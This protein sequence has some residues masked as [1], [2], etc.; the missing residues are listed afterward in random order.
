LL[1]SDDLR[2]IVLK[3]DKYCCLVGFYLCLFICYKVL[4][5]IL[6]EE[7]QIASLLLGIGR[8]SAQTFTSAEY[9]IFGSTRM[10][11]ALANIIHTNINS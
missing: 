5:D 7:M 8:K 11:S 2:G 4:S 9:H 3:A 1:G 10:E 6:K